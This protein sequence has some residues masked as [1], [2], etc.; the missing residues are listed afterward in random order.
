MVLHD[1]RR[2]LTHYN[3]AKANV[4]AAMANLKASDTQRQ[5]AKNLADEFARLSWIEAGLTTLTLAHPQAPGSWKLGS[6]DP[7]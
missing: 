3:A 2:T 7:M 4:K 5:G 1:L 6:S